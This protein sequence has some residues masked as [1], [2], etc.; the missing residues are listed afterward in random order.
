MVNP[1]YTVNLERLA[2]ADTL[3]YKVSITGQS[4]PDDLE[5]FAFETEDYGLAYEKARNYHN[6]LKTSFTDALVASYIEMPSYRNAQGAFYSVCD[7]APEKP[8][9]LEKEFYGPMAQE[10][11]EVSSRVATPDYNTVFRAVV[12]N[13]KL[14][15]YQERTLLS[16][17]KDKQIIWLD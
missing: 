2:G 6:F 15:M 5:K 3:R 1:T 12:A 16:Y 13:N 10:F 7:F 11:R 8:V 17:L 9:D 4:S 14:N